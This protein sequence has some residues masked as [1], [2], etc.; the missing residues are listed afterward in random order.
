MFQL[1]RFSL[2]KR[3]LS[4]ISIISNVVLFAVLGLAVHVDHFMD[5]TRGKVDTVYLDN[6][7]H[8]YHEAFLNIEHEEFSYEIYAGQN[9]DGCAV[10]HGE[11]PWIIE[12]HWQLD[13]DIIAMIRSD[14]LAVR[15]DM[16]REQADP[17]TRAFI[18][19]YLTVDMIEIRTEKEDAPN[20]VWI[21]IS[22]IYFLIMTYGSLIANE[23][24][25]EKATNT[26]SLIM[27]AVDVSR[28]F[29]AKVLTG[30]LALLIQMGALMA[31]ALFWLLFRAV[32]GSFDG[33][34][35]WISY[36]A[37]SQAIKNT[38]MHGAGSVIMTVF[39]I[40]VGVVTVQILLLM[41]ANQFHNSDEAASFQGPFYLVLMV[42]YYYLLINGNNEF[43]S[44]GL[45]RILSYV[46]VFSL[47][48][49]P[50]RLAIADATV[51]QALAALLISAVFLVLL[52][53]YYLP[54]YKRQLLR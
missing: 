15:Q 48:L 29:W 17:K 40:M 10:I 4:R 43:I 21:I 22:V 26:L 37:A 18:D 33:L 38:P 27:T 42:I 24:I 36:A 16:Y 46:P 7:I 35:R 13:E 34:N 11:H 25:Y 5:I 52:V 47:L 39:L 19:E 3:F 31:Y 6:S 32:F 2:E 23:V 41:A 53:K 1:I 14:I 12:S 49:M 50:C 30:Y 51:I 44:S 54:V 9:R 45:S 28:H 8:D 20:D